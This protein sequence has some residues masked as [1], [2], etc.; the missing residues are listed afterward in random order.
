MI[1]N[2]LTGHENAS[3]NREIV[4]NELGIGYA[5]A[6]S[7]LKRLNNYGITKEAFNKAMSLVK[8]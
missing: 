8:K 7:F 2:Q 3:K 5:N 1:E 4:G 6:K